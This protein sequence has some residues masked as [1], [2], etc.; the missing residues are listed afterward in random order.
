GDSLERW[1]QHLLAKKGINTFGDLPEGSLKVVTSDLSRGRI[2]VIPDDLETYNILPER[3]SVARAVRMSSSLPF[4]YEPD[5]LYNR[6]GEK[7]VII[8]GGVLSNFPLW[9]FEEGE[10]KRKR[11]VIGFQLST[12][13]ENQPP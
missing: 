12:R 1:V 11:P 4:F 9:L 8:D 3:F 10:R 5:F 7:G 6:T 13:L 2:L